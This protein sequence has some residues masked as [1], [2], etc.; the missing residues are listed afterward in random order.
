MKDL[1]LK[2][3]IRRVRIPISS[4]YDY[5]KILNGIFNLT[6][7]EM[8]VLSEI[9]RRIKLDIPAFTTP[10]KEGIAKKLELK[11]INN[12]ITKLTSKSAIIK[13]G[14]TYTVN[15]ILIPGKHRHIM[16]DLDLSYERR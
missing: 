7:M 8:K 6:D 13:T 16:F 1:Q 5:V 4:V 9:I 3:P 2:G 15:P 12:Y 10:A 11:T 14:S